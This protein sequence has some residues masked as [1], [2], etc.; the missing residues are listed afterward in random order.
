MTLQQENGAPIQRR[1][2][3][4]SY[5]IGRRGS[6]DFLAET[7]RSE[8]CGGIENTNAVSGQSLR[9]K[10]N[11]DLEVA[12]NVFI[13][14]S[15]TGDS[16][17]RFAYGSCTYAAGKIMASSRSDAPFMMKNGMPNG[18]SPHIP[19]MNGFEGH[20]RSGV[21]GAGHGDKPLDTGV[22]TA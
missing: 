16:L 17:I 18:S 22:V 21:S 10:A 4:L 20:D 7:L 13:T 2:S 12:P 15:L 14:G 19:A 8:V 9:D 1:V 5:V 6:L 3:G 11:D